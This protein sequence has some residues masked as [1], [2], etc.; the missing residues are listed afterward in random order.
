M[1]AATEFRMRS[2]P[3][4]MVES[5]Q[6]AKARHREFRL[7]AYETARRDALTAY[8][9]GPELRLE[10][11]DAHAL[12]VWRTRWARRRHAIGAGGWDW[13]SLVERQPRRAAIL[14]LAI[15]YGDDL[16]GL[17]L[18]RASR[19]RASGVRHTI[20]IT[21][22]ERRPEPPEVLLHGLIVPISVS[23]GRN[24]GAALGAKRL[25]LRN[26]DP[27]LLRYYQLLGFRVA[28]RG[29]RPV[30]CEQEI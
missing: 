27:K 14:P 26:P 11:V 13:S 19:R 20:T 22:A 24:Y 5:F 28:W 10:D 25:R 17:A 9:L 12:E 7:V 16:C 18:G 30:Y 2:G 1:I 6:Q 23:V 15:W 3:D 21:H 29:G 4:R 8:A